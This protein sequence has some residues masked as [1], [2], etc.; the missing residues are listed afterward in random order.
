[1]EIPKNLPV[2][3]ECD[4]SVSTQIVIQAMQLYRADDKKMDRAV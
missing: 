3:F 4:H 1:M 2:L